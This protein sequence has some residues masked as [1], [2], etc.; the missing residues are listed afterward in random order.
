[1][2]KK[3][4]NIEI[5]SL[6]VRLGG[7]NILA[8]DSYKSFDFIADEDSFLPK[9]IIRL[10]DK[11]GDTFRSFFNLS[12]GT[13]VE[14][15]IT[16]SLSETE[17]KSNTNDTS[18]YSIQLTN[19]AISAVYSSSDSVGYGSGNLE[20]L[21]EHPWAITQDFNSHAYAGKSNSE[22]IKSLLQNAS[23]RGFKFEDLDSEI[24]QSTDEDGTIP[25][26]NCGEGDLNFIVNK[27]LPYSTINNNP[28]VFFV[29]DKNNVHLESFQS[30][31]SKESKLLVVGGDEGDVDDT[32]R[33]RAAALG[34]LAISTN[35]LSKIGDKVPDRYTKLLKREISIDDCSNLLTY[36]GKLLPKVAISKYSQGKTSKGY[37]PV[38]LSRM[39]TSDA[40][41]KVCYTNHMYNDLKAIALN[42]QK[43]FNSF[44]KI[45][46]DV[47]FC[48]HLISVGDNV[49]IKI[50]ILEDENGEK[51]NHWMDGKWHV[52]A[53]KYKWDPTAGVPGMTLTLTRPSFVFNSNTTIANRD[54][55]Y[56]VGMTIL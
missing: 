1:M 22:I 52:K 30:M 32:M 23:S 44:F 47:S 24:F 5:P 15:A 8:S 14:V 40:T 38:S 2:A 29:D 11:G 37:I 36:T 34:G 21:C 28:V 43:D 26:Y 9:C 53:I 4:P 25:R 3:V 39:I 46:I 19:L 50:P 16:E 7:L 55:F 42:E 10:D 13:N 33:K 51:V 56:G 18:S 20:L 27:L 35:L 49:E 41:D 12:I 6:N 31:Y 17:R 45:D 54:E 48:G